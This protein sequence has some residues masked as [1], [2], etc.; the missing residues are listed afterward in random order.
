MLFKKV[1]RIDRYTFTIFKESSNLLFNLS[2]YLSLAS[3]IMSEHSFFILL[4][5]SSQTLTIHRTAGERRLPSFIPLYHFLR[6]RKLRNLFATLHVRWVSR[7]FNRNACVSQTATRWDLPPYR[8]TIWEVDWWCD[9]CLFT[10]WIGT[11]FLLQRFELAST[12]IL[13][14]KANR[15]TK[16]A[17]YPNVLAFIWFTGEKIFDLFC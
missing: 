4:E 5:F 8:I 11:R 17:S 7:I 6:L 15:L 2:V 10:W 12:I 16:C 13:V 3:A 14:W 1:F 9:V